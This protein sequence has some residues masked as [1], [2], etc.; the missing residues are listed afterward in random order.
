MNAIINWIALNNTLMIKIGFSAIILLI[1]VYV[2][3]FFFVPQVKHISDSADLSDSPTLST[4]KVDSE[5]DEAEALSS[6]DVTKLQAEISTLKYKLKEAELEKVKLA[7]QS[8]SA[9]G[10]SSPTPAGA[11][12]DM[13]AE[14]SPKVAAVQTELEEKIKIL[15]AR[16]SEYEIIAEDIAEISKLRQENEELK[17]KVADVGSSKK[18][19]EEVEEV[20]EEEVKVEEVKE[21]EVKVEEVKVEE[22]ETAKTLNK[23][24]DTFGLAELLASEEQVV[25]EAASDVKP[26]AAKE[27]AVTTPDAT[28]EAADESQLLEQ[29]AATK[30][31]TGVDDSSQVVITSDVDISAEEKNSLNDFEQFKKMKKG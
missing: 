15:E 16:L 17:A 30:T 12:L 5:K 10:N 28:S 20:E 11:G 19:I 8:S 18:S 22:E 29:Y 14:A 6:E 31:T 3:R 26:E 23:P 27:L 13:V 7:S 2:F 9:T 1:V 24:D 25:A 21:E 4:E